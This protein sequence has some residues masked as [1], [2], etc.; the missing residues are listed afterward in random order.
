ME[1]IKGWRCSQFNS[2]II[3]SLLVTV[4]L[5]ISLPFL[6]S[7]KACKWDTSLNFTYGDPNNSSTYRLHVRSF[8]EPNVY[9]STYFRIERLNPNDKVQ[10]VMIIALQ[11]AEAFVKFIRSPHE[12]IS[13]LEGQPRQFYISSAKISGVDLVELMFVYPRFQSIKYIPIDTAR[14]I[15]KTLDIVIPD[16]IL[17]ASLLNP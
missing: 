13:V 2:F 12:P 5:L 4:G 10:D 14:E 11:E 17:C 9:N 7:S 3:M 6:V 8:A 15:G 16:I 1:S